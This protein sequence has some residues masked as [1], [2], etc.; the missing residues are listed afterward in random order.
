MNAYRY[1]FFLSCCL[2]VGACKY[3]DAA[4]KANQDVQHSQQPN[5]MLV[6]I[7][8]THQLPR[9]TD[10]DIIDDSPSIEQKE[11]CDELNSDGVAEQ[12]FKAKTIAERRARDAFDVRIKNNILQQGRPFDWNQFDS[13]M[14]CDA[15]KHGDGLLT[16]GIALSEGHADYAAAAMAL[17]KELTALS[18]GTIVEVTKDLILGLMTISTEC[19]YIKEIRGLDI[20][21]FVDIAYELNTQTA[22]HEPGARQVSHTCDN[23]LLADREV[24]TRLN[25]N[26]TI[27][28]TAAELPAMDELPHPSLYDPLTSSVSYDQYMELIDEETA[29]RMRR[30]GLDHVYNDYQYFGDDNLGIAIIDNGILPEAVDYLDR[31]KGFFKM[32]GYYSTFATRLAGRKNDGVHPRPFD[33]QV[34]IDELFGISRNNPLLSG[35]IGHGTRQAKE[36]LHIAPHINILSVR[37]TSSDYLIYPSH[38]RGLVRGI[39]AVANNPE[40]RVASVPLGSIFYSHSVKRAI[41][42]FN[43]RDKIIVAAAGSSTPSL[44]RILGVVFPANLPSTISATGIDDTENTGG[45]FQLGATSHGGKAIDFVVDAS[46]HSSRATA[47]TASMIGMLWSVNPTLNREQIIDILV[48]ASSSFLEKGERDSVFGWGKI[49][50]ALA[51]ELVRETL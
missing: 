31:G 17:S 2:S 12:P 6:S 19:Q 34:V 7:A 43:S 14:I 44:S 48:R 9:T 23:E 26:D 29:I 15:L 45:V 24:A 40:I 22:E 20:V 4:Q 28:A 50:M 47:M 49:D 39:L 5:E 37:A 42:Y 35:A 38:F 21:D 41:D 8:D 46:P 18:G 51:N 32:E 25:N 3:N 11:H 1:I 27:I 13:D 36:I 30:H 10:F 33:V 16:L